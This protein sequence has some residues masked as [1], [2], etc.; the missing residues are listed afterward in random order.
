MVRTAIKTAGIKPP[1]TRVTAPPGLEAVRRSNAD[2][3]YLFVINHGEEAAHL[4][5][6]GR[7]LVADRDVTGTLS[8]KAGAV[9]IVEEETD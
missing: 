1:I 9:A 4:R 6:K 5:T 8:L 3:S 2:A 7:D